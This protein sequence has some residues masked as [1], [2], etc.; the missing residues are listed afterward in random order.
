[1]LVQQ[2]YKTHQNYKSLFLMDFVGDYA[3]KYDIRQSRKER[4]ELKWA[5]WQIKY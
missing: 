3:T 1:M 5:I 2:K 4:K